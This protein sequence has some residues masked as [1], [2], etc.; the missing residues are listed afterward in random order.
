VC[1][2]VC[3]FGC[4]SWCACVCVWMC[5]FLCACFCVCGCVCVLLCMYICVLV[6]V[7]VHVKRSSTYNLSLACAREMH[8]N[9][10]L[11]QYQKRS[12]S[13]NVCAAKSASFHGR[14]GRGG[15]RKR[16]Q[17]RLIHTKTYQRQTRSSSTNSFVRS[18]AMLL[19]WPCLRLLP[20][21]LA[22]AHCRRDL[23]GVR[24]SR[25]CSMLNTTTKKNNQNM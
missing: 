12:S 2:F 22:A 20:M 21:H 9:S 8:S 4:V 13:M 25:T 15:L 23:Y 5:V 16:A 24:V 17:A 14:K 6:C 11:H 7:F 10:H 19:R 3:T 1:L 18:L